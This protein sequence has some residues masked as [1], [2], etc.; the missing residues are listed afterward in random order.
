MYLIFGILFVGVKILR[1]PIAS[2]AKKKRK[3]EKKN[4]VHTLYRHECDP[5]I[6]MFNMADHVVLQ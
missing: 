3:K 5:V 2:A 6:Q 4:Y 1:D